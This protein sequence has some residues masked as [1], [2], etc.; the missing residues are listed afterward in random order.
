MEKKVYKLVA[1][2]PPP[3]NTTNNSSP[4]LLTL[5]TPNTNNASNLLNAPPER[6]KTG[7]SPESLAR[8]GDFDYMGALRLLYRDEYGMSCLHIAAKNNAP[9]HL[10][11]SLITAGLNPDTKTLDGITALHVLVLDEKK[12]SNVALVKVLVENGANPNLCIPLRWRKQTPYCF[13]MPDDLGG[14]SPLM[15]VVKSNSPNAKEFV[16]YLLVCGADPKYQRVTDGKTA[17]TMAR[18]AGL[19][20]LA[21]SLSPN[22]HV[23]PLPMVSAECAFCRIVTPTLKSCTKC[24][25]V[26]YCGEQCQ[27]LHWADHRILCKQI[28]G[29]NNED[30]Y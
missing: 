21:D 25:M 24:R 22:A 30:S 8:F 18:E 15:L 13:E 1:T 29:A 9:A 12:N 2:A 28:A 10:V 16:R 26:K 11:E 3:T 6:I 5:P 17:E 19:V 20:E 7:A 4:S 27:K 23:V 14:C